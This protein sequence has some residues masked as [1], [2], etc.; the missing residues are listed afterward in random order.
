MKRPPRWSSQRRLE[1]LLILAVLEGRIW[2]RR[3]PKAA[4]RH[5]VGPDGVSRAF[6]GRRRVGPSRAWMVR[7][8]LE[9]ASFQGSRER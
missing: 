3:A 6:C 7:T 1:C 8:A 5:S 4:R 9:G 2:G